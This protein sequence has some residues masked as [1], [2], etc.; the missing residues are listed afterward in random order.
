MKFPTH[1]LLNPF[2]F[3]SLT[4]FHMIIKSKHPK[5][6]SKAPCLLASIACW[7]PPPL[8]PHSTNMFKNWV[9]RLSSANSMFDLGVGFT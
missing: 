9:V 1:I 4:Q 5:E 3:M 8:L 7:H 2:I 6:G